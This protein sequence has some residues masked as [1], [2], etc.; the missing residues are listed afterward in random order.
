[1]IKSVSMLYAHIMRFLVRAWKF[2]HESKLMHLVHSVTRPAALRYDDLLQSIKRDAESVRR[3]TV[4]NS[5]EEVRSVHN[6]VRDLRE[7]LET[8]LAG[9]QIDSDGWGCLQGKMDVLTEMLTDFRQSQ[10]WANAAQAKSQLEMHAS[11]S[12]F[13]TSQA[14]LTLQSQCSVDH[15]LVLQT[16]SA[17]QSYYRHRPGTSGKLFWNSPKLRTW[18]RSN[19]SCTILL[20]STHRE[21][22]QTRGFCVDVVEQI[23]KTPTPL[24]QSAPQRFKPSSRIVFWVLGDRGRT[25]SLI[26]TLKSLV[27]QALCFRFTASTI[28]PSEISFHVNKFRDAYFEDDY[29]EILGSLLHDFKLI[30]TFQ[31][32]FISPFLITGFPR[33]LPGELEIQA[34]IID[35]SDIVANA[36][37]FAPDT[38]AHCRD[39]LRR[40]SRMLSERKS[41]TVL[42][43][44]TTAYGP[45]ERKKDG[46]APQ[47]LVLDVG[48]G[49]GRRT[50]RQGLGRSRTRT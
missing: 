16:A 20:K 34:Q 13:H 42:K 22:I 6:E 5:Q 45:L 35:K 39:S 40:L 49:R 37:A 11:M 43:I 48:R 14:L 9:R 1:M 2:Y 18:D 7:K 36:E 4:T 24:K 38:A 26:E 27:Y 50:P 12:D 33:P 10:A 32:P 29:L 31:P 3:L 15:K 23:L 25:Y 17:E 41:E 19:S 8:V 44:L 28:S 21:R 47:D 30:C 46:D